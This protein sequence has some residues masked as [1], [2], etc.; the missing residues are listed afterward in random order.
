MI[1]RKTSEE[2][3][4]SVPVGYEA[5]AELR[6]CD[7]WTADNTFYLDVRA[8]LTFVRYLPDYP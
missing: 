6:G 4:T 8:A 5:L 7:F 2:S 1:P 3:G